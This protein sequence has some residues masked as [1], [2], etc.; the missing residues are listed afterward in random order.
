MKIIVLI[1]GTS[2]GSLKKIQEVTKII[3]SYIKNYKV[4]VV[5]SAMARGYKR[6]I[7]K[8]KKLAKIFQ[9]MKKMYFCPLASKFH[10]L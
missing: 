2:V 5:S 7:T 9:M 1:V 6:F 3:I 4:I 10:M 8:T